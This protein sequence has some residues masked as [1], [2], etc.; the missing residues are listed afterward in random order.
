M[1]QAPSPWLKY[2]V[3][4]NIFQRVNSKTNY[5]YLLLTLPNELLTN[6]RPLGVGLSKLRMPC[7]MLDAHL[8]VFLGENV[9]RTYI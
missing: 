1:L 2:N 6:N 7:D 5:R 3:R 4:V 9:S 8:D